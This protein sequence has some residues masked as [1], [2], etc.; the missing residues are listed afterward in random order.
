MFDDCKRIVGTTMVTTN[1]LVI[2]NENW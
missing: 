1:S 2:N